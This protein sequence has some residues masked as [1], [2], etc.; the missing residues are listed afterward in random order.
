MGNFTE[1]GI[2]INHKVRK[3]QCYSIFCINICEEE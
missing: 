3:T 2:E 1:A